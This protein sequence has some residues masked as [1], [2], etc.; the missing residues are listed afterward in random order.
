[1]FPSVEVCQDC[2]S[3]GIRFKNDFSSHSSS[4]WI[5]PYAGHFLFRPCWVPQYGQQLFTHVHVGFHSMDNSSLLTSMLG[6]TV[7]TTALYSRP[8]WVPQFGQ[9]LFTHVHVGFHSMDNSSLLTS[10]LGSK[11]WTTALYSRHCATFLSIVPRD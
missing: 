11:V 9:Q 6:S 3:C 5:W 7:W 10:M 8:C 1:M 4:R 2:R